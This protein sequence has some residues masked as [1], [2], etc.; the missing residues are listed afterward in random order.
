MEPVLM[1]RQIDLH[2]KMLSTMQ[3]SFKK[4]RKRIHKVELSMH[5]KPPD[6]E[7]QEVNVWKN[8]VDNMIATEKVVLNLFFFFLF[9][10]FP[11]TG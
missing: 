4:V 5:L 8:K 7:V 10:I 11:H 3:H 6:T 9:E 2:E 1:D